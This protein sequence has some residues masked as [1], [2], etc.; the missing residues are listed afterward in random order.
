MIGISAGSGM[1]EVLKELGTMC[2]VTNINL[3]ALLENYIYPEKKNPAIC[4]I[5]GIIMM[6]LRLHELSR[7][8]RI[9]S[10]LLIEG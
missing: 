9:N 7:I 3:S 2:P 5:Y 6:S 10:I 1:S 8:Q 4:L